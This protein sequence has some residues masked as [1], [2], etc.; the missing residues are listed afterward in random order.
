[1]P[2]YRPRYLVLDYSGVR[3]VRGTEYATKFAPLPILPD[4]RAPQKDASRLLG[5]R[6][7]RIPN[8]ADISEILVAYSAHFPT[9]EAPSGYNAPFLSRTR[10]NADFSG[11]VRDPTGPRPEKVR[12]VAAVMGSGVGKTPKWSRTS[13]SGAPLPAFV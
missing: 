11:K 5:P 1:M 10:E 3:A 4:I 7:R 8:L 2:C 12:E 9:L 6:T 13:R